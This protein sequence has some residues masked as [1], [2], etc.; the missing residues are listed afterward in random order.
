L[1]IL[2]EAIRQLAIFSQAS[3]Q[4][5]VFTGESSIGEATTKGNEQ[6]DKYFVLSIPLD[7]VGPRCLVPAT[8]I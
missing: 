8:L 6:M 2:H 3:N 4:R 5:N 1:F 7:L